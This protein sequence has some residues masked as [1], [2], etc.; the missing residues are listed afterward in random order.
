M[1]RVRFT[2]GPLGLLESEHSS[3][4]VPEVVQKGDEGEYV[5]PHP[6]LA[7]WHI[8]RVTVDGQQRIC[9]CAAAQFERL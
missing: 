5:G 3:R 9:P 4:F 1:Q 7:G 2:R 8:I 6:V